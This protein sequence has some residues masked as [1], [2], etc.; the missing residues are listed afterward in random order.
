MGIEDT[1]MQNKI[2]SAIAAAPV[3]SGT[4]QAWDAVHG[5]APLVQHLSQQQLHQ[6]GASSQYNTAEDVWQQ[7]AEVHGC[8]TDCIDTDDEL[9]WQHLETLWGGASCRAHSCRP[10]AAAAAASRATAAAAAASRATTAAAS[11]ATTA[12][13]QQGHGSSS[14]SQQGHGSHWAHSACKQTQT[15]WASVPR[16]ASCSKVSGHLAVHQPHSTV[17]GCLTPPS[18]EVQHQDQA[19]HALHSQPENRLQQSGVQQAK[20]WWKSLFNRPVQV[21]AVSAGTGQQQQRQQSRQA[22]HR[23]PSLLSAAAGTA[24]IADLPARSAAL[25]R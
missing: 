18:P 6:Q 16:A 9:H 7:Q 23:Q 5:D 21:P 17:S 3:S 1:A 22:A 25:P 12:A 20:H 8:D 24:R 15:S 14:S 19:A 13:G 11:R 2:L 4:E 10:V